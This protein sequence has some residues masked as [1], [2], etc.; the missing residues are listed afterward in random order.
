MFDLIKMFV[1]GTIL[2]TDEL[3]TLYSNGL[4]IENNGGL[5]LT[6]L[7]KDFLNSTQDLK[8]S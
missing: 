6:Q 7:G 3:D 2:T 4:I 1:D 5:V 8:L